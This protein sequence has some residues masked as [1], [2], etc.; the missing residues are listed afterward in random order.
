MLFLFNVTLFSMFAPVLLLCHANNN[1]LPSLSNLPPEQ[2][3][4]LLKKIDK[5]GD[6]KITLQEFRTLFDKK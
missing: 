4:K 6:G 1:Y 2:R 5:D 3:E